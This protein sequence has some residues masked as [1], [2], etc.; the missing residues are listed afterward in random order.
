MSKRWQCQR[1]R[2]INGSMIEVFFT[3]DDGNRQ[4]Q[5]LLN[6]KGDVNDY[7]VGKFYWRPDKPTSHD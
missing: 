6:I 7:E 4:E 5:V 2:P 1:V 3:R